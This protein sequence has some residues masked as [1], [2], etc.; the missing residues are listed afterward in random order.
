MKPTEKT[1]LQLLEEQA[2]EAKQQQIAFKGA[3]IK[4]L[5]PAI[6]ACAGEYKHEQI[7]EALGRAGVDFTLRTFRVTLSRVRAE[8]AGNAAVS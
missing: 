3:I 5:L 7:V 8:A 2:V 1:A 4:R 6:E